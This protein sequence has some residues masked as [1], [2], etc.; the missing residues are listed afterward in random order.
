MKRFTR[1]LAV[2]TSALPFALSQPAPAQDTYPSKPITMIIGWSAGAQADVLLR[3]LAQGMSKELNDQPIVVVNKPGAAG[4]LGL[5]A[6]KQAKPDGYTLG[7]SVSSNYLLAPFLNKEA[8]GM[9]EA[10]TQ[11]ACF[12]DYQFGLVVRSDAPWKTWNEFRDYAKRNPGKVNYATSGIG[13]TQHIIFERIAEKEG[14]K[15]THI[16]YKG[17]NETIQGLVGGHIDAA[18]QGPG[19]TVSF[20]REG[21]LRM[22][23]SLNDTRWEAAPNVP[24]ILE[25]GYDFSAFS[26]ACIH[27]PKGLPEPIRAKL[28]AAAEKVIKD[29]NSAYAEKARSLQVAAIYMGGREYT[30]AIEDRVEGFGKIIATLGLK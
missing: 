15:W 19:D 14:I 18:I 23:M 7:F 27:G 22:L 29:P 9:L 3:L 20:L 4:L 26:K 12:F 11:I 24:T 17:G 13:T 21:R 30:K 2:L 5:E 16:A 6:V 1:F 25:S 10:S 28:E 8:A